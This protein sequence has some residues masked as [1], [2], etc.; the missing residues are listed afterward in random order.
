MMY[1]FSHVSRHRGACFFSSQKPGVEGW[2]RGGETCKD[3]KECDKGSEPG[4]D[5]QRGCRSNMKD[6]SSWSRFFAISKSREWT[7]TSVE[8][9][10]TCSRHNLNKVLGAS[11]DEFSISGKI[12]GCRGPLPIYSGS[13]F[14]SFFF[15]VF[16][17]VPV[18]RPSLHFFF[19]PFSLIL[20][21][22][23]FLSFLRSPR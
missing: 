6:Y 9:S 2:V 14:S 15:L 23:L 21:A 1:S 13:V 11:P 8:M 3:T 4:I 20:N 18:L 16:P 22:V 12:N 10:F 7:S 17:L 5:G 19:L